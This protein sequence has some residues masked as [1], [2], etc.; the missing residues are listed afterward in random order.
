MPRPEPQFPDLT[1]R[2]PPHSLESE[3]ALLG[4]ILLEAG[5]ERAGQTIDRCL[6]KLRGD[7]DF[8]DLSHR[9]IWQAFVD[10]D[11]AGSAVTVITVMERLRQWGKLEQ[12]GGAAFL[13][14]L[15][16]A[17]GSPAGLDSYLE[18]V[19]ERAT[20]RRLLAAATETIA[21]VHDHNGTAAEQVARA[22]QAMLDLSEGTESH[23]VIT[24]K[25]A[26]RDA[27]DLIERIYNHRGKGL[28][29]G[30]LT[31]LSFLDKRIGGLEPGQVFYIGAPQSTG[32]TSLLLTIMRYLVVDAGIPV[33]FMSVES[34]VQEV[35]M[36]MACNMAK[37]NWAHARS[38][39]IS[40]EDVTKFHRHIPLLAKAPW[41][42]VDQ[43]SV[44][45]SELR[46]H[47]RRLVTQHGCKLIVIDHFHRLHDPEARDPRMEAKSIVRSIRWVARELKV[48][49][50]VAA[51]VSRE[52]KKEAAARGR[53]KPQATDV[54]EAADIEEDADVM[55]I[56]AKDFPD[57]EEIENGQQGFDPDG[58]IW[59]MNLEIVKQRNGPTGPVELTFQRPFF[60]YEDRHLGTGDV[61]RGRRKA[62]KQSEQKQQREMIDVE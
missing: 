4:C 22:Q 39:F 23:R 32:K 19:C 25:E 27:I 35:Y 56:L 24:S 16:D 50:I 14:G 42:I 47:C 62:E 55:G 41:F 48:P 38:G 53:R 2:L 57:T 21:E 36:R 58:H 61:E 52:A 59:P 10:L 18:I 3:Q 6:Q 8:Y 37:V 20:Q 9:L 13:A 49:V 45:P 12:I 29:E 1:D 31:G 43:G 33:G 7:L 28:Q 34:R 5:R 30:L 17:A 51:Q 40:D 26:A 54:R 44:S 15:E 60:R 11:A 46:R